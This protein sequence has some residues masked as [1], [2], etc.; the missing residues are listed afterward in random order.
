MRTAD[1]IK[2]YGTQTKV[3][4][5]LKIGKSAVNQWPEFVPEGKAR[6]LEK[7]TRGKLKVD[8]SAYERSSIHNVGAKHTEQ[9]GSKTSIRDDGSSVNAKKVAVLSC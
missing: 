1:V 3:A 9:E 2:F 5:V 7:I 6:R 4:K 8:E